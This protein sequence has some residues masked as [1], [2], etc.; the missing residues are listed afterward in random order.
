MKNPKHKVCLHSNDNKIVAAQCNPGAWSQIFE[1]QILYTIDRYC[2]FK[3][4]SYVFPSD[5]KW[6]ITIDG[7]VV[8]NGTCLTYNE[9]ASSYE[10]K[11]CDSMND[12]QKWEFTPDRQLRNVIFNVCVGQEEKKI[13]IKKCDMTS[14]S[15]QWTCD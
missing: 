11:E 5:G 10:N 9:S 13:V 6:A 8:D 12:Y 2:T 1:F 7:Y 14:K 4:G 15:Q 3:Q